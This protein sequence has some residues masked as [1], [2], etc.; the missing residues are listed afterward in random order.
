M[1]V[2]LR[3]AKS[4]RGYVHG[5][6]LPALEPGRMIRVRAGRADR[7]ALI[8]TG[9]MVRT[10]LDIAQQDLDAAVWSVPSIKPLDAAQVAEVAAGSRG[11]AVLEEHSTYGGLGAAVAEITSE[12]RPVRVL[13]IGV[14]D[15]YSEHCGTYAYLLK[16]HGLDVGSVSAQI[17][18][19]AAAQG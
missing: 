19:F 6:A 13:R 7:P 16:E 12:H 1:P 2:Y 9:S 3:M 14:R 4:D 10:A 15:R 18:A 17:H 5:A 11:L 8:A